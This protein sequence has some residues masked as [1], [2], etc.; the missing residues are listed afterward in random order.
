MNNGGCA[1]GQCQHQLCAKRVPIFSSLD[2]EELNKVVGLIIR[3]QY[4]KGETIL[5][6]GSELDSLNIVNHGMVKAFRYTQEGKEQILYIFSEGDF[7]GEKNLLSRQEATY[8][9]E[10]LEPTHICMIRS[11]DF[12]A[13]IREY[14]DI[15]LKIIRELSRR[16]DRLEN[17][18]QN[19][20]TKN[21]EAR[22]GAVLLEFAEKYGIRHPAGSS[23]NCLSAG[24]ESRIISASPGKR[25]AA[26]SITFRRKA[27][28]IWS[29]TRKSS[30]KTKR[31]CEKSWNKSGKFFM[32][33]VGRPE[34]RYL[35]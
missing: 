2:E 10:A 28:S 3:R 22:I 19:M 32:H 4:A 24:K 15:S 27:S 5:L 33:P 26:G 8:N 16:L 35:P 13:L 25:S 23:S 18:V 6:E 17:A 11:R 31:R 21:A 14:P 9:V 12:Q 34:P 30:L 29:E 20:G 1:C 7:F